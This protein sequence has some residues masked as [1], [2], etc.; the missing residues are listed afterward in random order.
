MDIIEEL[1]KNLTALDPDN[2]SVYK[3]NFDKYYSE[4]VE[5]EKEYDALDTENKKV[6][7]ADRFAFRYLFND[8]DI[9]YLAAFD[10]CSADVDVSFETITNMI[11]V[12]KDE[13]IN[14][15]SVLKDSTYSIYQSILNEVDVEVV[16]L[17]S[18]QSISK[19][20][21]SKTS[22]LDIMKSNLEI[23]KGLLK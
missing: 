13:K 6:V 17:D 3:T 16:E 22:Y 8:Y 11:D 18:M 4:L 15:I 5:L 14:K 1:Y 7:I 12:V 19:S 20:N 21:L 9:D 10:G 23:L 2:A